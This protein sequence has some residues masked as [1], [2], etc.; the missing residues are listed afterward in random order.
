MSDKAEFM[1]IAPNIHVAGQLEVADIDRLVKLGV[2]TLV[3]NRPDGEADQTSSS[4][5]AEAAAESGIDFVYLPMTT[6]DDTSGHS[7]RMKEVLEDGGVVMAYCRT[8][9]R[10][11]AL[12]EAAT[13]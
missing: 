13:K 12:C 11:S 3:C 8:G 6:P 1:Q 2:N 10:S 5:I 4:V 9:R 7:V